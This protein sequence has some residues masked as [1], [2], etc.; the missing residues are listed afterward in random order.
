VEA[1]PLVLLVKLE[2]VEAGEPSLLVGLFPKIV[3]LLVLVEQA[4]LLLLELEALE[5]LLCTL[6]S[7]LLG[8]AEAVEARVRE[9]RVRPHRLGLQEA[10]AEWVVVEVPQSAGLHLFLVTDMVVRVEQP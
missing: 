1:E 8:V 6:V 5:E 3:S 10:E 9:L 4:G 7:M 2:A